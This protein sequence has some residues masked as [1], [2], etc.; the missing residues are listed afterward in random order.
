MKP[1]FFPRTLSWTKAVPSNK[2]PLGPGLTERFAREIEAVK[3]Q[4]PFEDLKWKHPCLRLK[5]RRPPFNGLGDIGWFLAGFLVEE[6]S[7]FQPNEFQINTV[8]GLSAIW[9]YG[10]TYVLE[11]NWVPQCTAVLGFK[12]LVAA[13]SCCTKPAMR[14]WLASRQQSTATYVQ[15]VD[16]NHSNQLSYTQLPQ[17]HYI[18]TPSSLTTFNNHFQQPT[19]AVSFSHEG[20]LRWPG[21][22]SGVAAPTVHLAAAVL[23]LQSLGS[24][25]KKCGFRSLAH[26]MFFGNPMEPISFNNMKWHNRTS[27][28]YNIWYKLI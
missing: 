6:D 9:R 13:I 22:L 3:T 19:A 17:L 15:P 28:W 18:S 1:D 8:A 4:Y 12:T 24:H 16:S 26:V 2:K 5:S 11:L 14:I 21:P 20:G 27:I 7:A 23:I 25:P 10:C